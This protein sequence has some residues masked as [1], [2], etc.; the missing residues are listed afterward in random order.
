[1]NDNEL[2]HR[3]RESTFRLYESVLFQ[4]IESSTGPI[5]VNPAPLR[6]TTYAA[7]VRD[8][9]ISFTKFNWSPAMFTQAELNAADLVVRHSD[10][11][12][13]IG[14]RGEFKR[15]HI[16]GEARGFVTPDH[17]RL[18]GIPIT[19][20]LTDHEVTAFA[21]LLGGRLI[22]GPVIIPPQFPLPEELVSALESNY[23]IA[24]TITPEHTLIL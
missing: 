16:G 23:D 4:A 12:V 21:I 1:M 15:G 9:I 13:V 7:R 17:K 8:A 24:I 5:N 19:R 18:A 3:L 22:S 20:A 6:P 10:H 11:A 2:P 14:R